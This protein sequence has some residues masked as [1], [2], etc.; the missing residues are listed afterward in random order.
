MREISKVL[1]VHSVVKSRRNVDILVFVHASSIV[2]SRLFRNRIEKR[3]KRKSCRR[4]HNI[5]E[6]NQ[7]FKKE[8]EKKRK[9]F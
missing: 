3:S 1:I 9:P 5:E 4:R 6:C 8:W 7:T 2:P